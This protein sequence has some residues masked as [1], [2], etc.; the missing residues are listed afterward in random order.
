M[1]GAEGPGEVSKIFYDLHFSQD[2][3]MLLPLARVNSF[4]WSM[5]CFIM[6]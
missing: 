4:A 6:A 5:L 2:L 1:S 3:R